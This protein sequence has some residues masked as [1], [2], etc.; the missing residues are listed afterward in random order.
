MDGRKRAG[1]NDPVLEGPCVV[2]SEWI[3]R[4]FLKLQKRGTALTSPFRQS[5]RSYIQWPVIA[6]GLNI[7][8]MEREANYIYWYF[9][10]SRLNLM[11][12]A[13]ESRQ[14]GP[15][16]ILYPYVHILHL[17]CFLLSSSYAPHVT[18]SSSHHPTSCIQ[19]SSVLVY[20]WEWVCSVRRV[21]VD[22]QQRWTSIWVVRKKFT[23]NRI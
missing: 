13:V 21:N 5:S 9:Q 10:I 6:S 12:R 8:W 22:C 14:S 2:S 20:Y 15:I 11:A 4:S 3:V 17:H 16:S 7:M 1:Q 23:E 19:C 18:F